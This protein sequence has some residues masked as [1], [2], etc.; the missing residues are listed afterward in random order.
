MPRE[1][2]PEEK[3]AGHFIATTPEEKAEELFRAIRDYVRGELDRAI[4]LVKTDGQ[5]FDETIGEMITDK[6][7]IDVLESATKKVCVDNTKELREKLLKALTPQEKD[8]AR[9][10]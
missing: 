8:D 3:A 1:F 10:T 6:F 4:F 5:N 2:T 7:D 9:T